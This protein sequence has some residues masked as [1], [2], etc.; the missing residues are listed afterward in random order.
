MPLK[1]TLLALAIGLAVLPAH[2][3]DPGDATIQELL[4]RLAALEA[5]LAAVEGRTEIPEVAEVD[6]R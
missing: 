4:A 5:R 2:A 3:A 6:Q 1:R